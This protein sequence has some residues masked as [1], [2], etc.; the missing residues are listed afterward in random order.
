MYVRYTFFILCDSKT[1]TTLPTFHFRLWHIFIDIPNVDLD[2]KKL[3]FS[4]CSRICQLHDFAFNNMAR[5]VSDSGAVNVF[6]WKMPLNEDGSCHRHE[7]HN[8]RVASLKSIKV[9]FE[10]R[11]KT[12]KRKR[13]I[14]FYKKKIRTPI[15]WFSILNFSFCGVVEQ[16]NYVHSSWLTPIYNNNKTPKLSE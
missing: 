10:Y 16:S 4:K 5:C 11:A 9:S 8:F 7:F 14:T 6:K 12:G 15:K 2:M 1:T 13:R 3:W